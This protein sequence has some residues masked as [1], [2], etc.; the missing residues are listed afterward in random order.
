MNDHEDGKNPE[1]EDED[2][3]KMPEAPE[4]LKG[5]EGEDGRNFIK[6]GEY[7]DL[8]EKDPTLKRL[9]VGTGWDQKAMEEAPVDIDLCLFLLDKND[10]T[11]MDGDFV[12]YNNPMAC[13]NA[14]KHMGDNRSGAGDGDDEVAFLDLTGIPFDVAKVMLVLSVYDEE[15]EHYIAPY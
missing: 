12:F 10:Q 2:R 9:L 6:A 3:P 14:V 5:I 4:G 13:D 7:C 15:L 1:F 11:R 8:Q